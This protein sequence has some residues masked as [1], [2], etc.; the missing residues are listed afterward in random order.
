VQFE[1]KLMQADEWAKAQNCAAARG[2]LTGDAPGMNMD[3]RSARQYVMLAGIALS[4]GQAKASEELLQKASAQ[5]DSADL[6]WAIQAEKS[7]G[8]YHAEEAEQR[9][10]TR[11]AAA[12]SSAETGANSGS[13]WYNLGMLQAALKHGEQAR[14]SFDKAL[15]LPDAHMS[16]HLAR[17]ALAALS[18][19][20]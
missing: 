20:R 3:G 13:W 15:I 19:A 14:E 16:H 10:A 4:C 12:E 11:L 5:V 8:T 2:F 7:L 9:L 17:E 1:I 6:A 18:A